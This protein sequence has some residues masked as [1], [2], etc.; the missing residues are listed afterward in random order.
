[1]LVAERG[2]HRVFCSDTLVPPSPIYV[3]YGVF[4]NNEHQLQRGNLWNQILS[5]TRAKKI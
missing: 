3:Q 5:M 2:V 4:P 1:M